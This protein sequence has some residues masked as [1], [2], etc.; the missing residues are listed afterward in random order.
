[1]AGAG[2]R[3]GDTQLLQH[4]A[5]I[6]ASKIA[7][8]NRNQA[9]QGPKSHRDTP[10]DCHPNALNQDERHE[11]QKRSHGKNRSRNQSCKKVQCDDGY[12]YISPQ[13]QNLKSKGEA[14]TDALRA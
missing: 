8:L 7:C 11:S 1:M 14:V 10:H 4:A 5:K 6:D 13:A 3:L 12:Q 9:S 2:I